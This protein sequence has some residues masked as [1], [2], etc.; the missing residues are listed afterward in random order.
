MGEVL[1]E[2]IVQIDS[3]LVFPLHGTASHSSSLWTAWAKIHPLF[4]FRDPVWVGREVCPTGRALKVEEPE[5]EGR[6]LSVR[7]VGH[8]PLILS[9]VAGFPSDDADGRMG[10]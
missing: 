6:G 9:V 1:D 8:P 3:T 7:A 5:D 2:K 10:N 4:R